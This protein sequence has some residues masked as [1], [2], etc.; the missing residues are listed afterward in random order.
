MDRWNGYEKVEATIVSDGGLL[1]MKE[2]E[3]DKASA[4]DT[5]C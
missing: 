1:P 5:A 3:I 4:R 2:I